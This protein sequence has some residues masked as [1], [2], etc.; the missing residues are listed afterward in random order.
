MILCMSGVE[1]STAP[2]AVR[3]RLSFPRSGVMDMDRRVFALPHVVGTALLSTCNRTELYLHWAG[4]E[5][6]SP[7]DLLCQAANVSSEGFPLVTRQGREC[8]RHLMEVSCGLCSQI[9]GEDQILTQV[10]A[11]VTLAR[12]AGTVDNVLETL[13]RTAV[14]C[15]KAAKTGGRLTALPASAAHRAVQVL[16]ERLGTLSGKR[17]LVIGNGEMGRLAASL[18][19]RAGCAVT[20]TLRSYHYGETLVPAGCSVT[21]YEDRYAAMEGMDIILSAT[22]SPHYT[23]MAE[24]FAGVANPPKLLVDL[25]VPRDIQPEITGATVLNVDDLG[26]TSGSDDGLARVSD[27]IDQYM[28]RFFRWSNYRESLPVLEEV[29]AAVWERVQDMETE[30]AVR[31]AVDLL[32]G[33]LR[34]L[35]SSDA[36]AA[37]AARIRNH[38]R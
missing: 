15:G 30:E 10:R 28:E 11:A 21:P 3:E 31:K 18:L 22:T 9:L 1:Y 19:R 12:E 29:K 32:L 5:M 4:E 26:Q 8:V 38:T 17:A 23:V 13:F 27:T 2:V 34:E 16:E 6:P 33:G 14:T 36:L 37:C 7:G 25:A 35:P 24:P 20:V